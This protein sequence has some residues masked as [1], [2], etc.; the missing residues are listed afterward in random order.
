MQHTYKSQLMLGIYICPFRSLGNLVLTRGQKFR[1]MAS[2]IKVNDALI[3]AW[4]ATIAAA[5]EIIIPVNKNHDGMRKK[6]GLSPFS[7]LPDLFKSHAP[8]PK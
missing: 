7:V 3:N 4:L 6:N 1:R 8:C 2:F 5:V